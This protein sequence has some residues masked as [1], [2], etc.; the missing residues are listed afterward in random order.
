M[1]DV[2]SKLSHSQIR[3]LWLWQEL[4]RAAERFTKI[5]AWHPLTLTKTA[6]GIR[7]V[8][9]QPEGGIAHI[10]ISL[11]STEIPLRV[12]SVIDDGPTVLQSFPK[13][14]VALRTLIDHI[15]SV[16][17][18][19][20]ADLA[21]DAY[22]E[23]RW[24]EKHGDDPCACGHTR[25]EHPMEDGCR[26]GECK[27]LYWDPICPCG[28]PQSKHHNEDGYCEVR[29]DRWHCECPQFGEPLQNYQTSTE[30]WFTEAPGGHRGFE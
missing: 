18:G 29:S 2:K 6:S 10:T 15:N 7:F 11:I 5:C 9:D 23:E 4:M 16:V 13:T 24:L 21:K 19:V 1:S 25:R 14:A 8:E 22:Y 3:E 20:E 30:V 28:H 12:R 27:C 26:S 17:D